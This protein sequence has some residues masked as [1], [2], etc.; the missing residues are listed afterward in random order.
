MAALTPQS[1]TMQTVPPRLLAAPLLTMRGR[2]YQVQFHLN[3]FNRTD[4]PV[5]LK[6]VELLWF[7]GGQQLGRRVLERPL[8]RRLLRAVPWP[9]M[10]DRKSIAA[11]HRWRGKLRRP[12]GHARV[13]AGAGVTLPHQLLITRE[14]RLPDGLKLVLVH[15]GGRTVLQVVVERF[16][17]RTRLRLP[18]RGR[19]WVMA[20]HRFDEHHG[21]GFINSQ[22]FS[23]DLGRLAAGHSTSSGDARQNASYKCH[24]QAVVA[25]ADGAVAEVHDNVPENTPVGARP[26]WQQVLRQPWDLAGNFV[27]LRHAPGEFTAYLHLR[28]GLA[29]KRGA[30]VKAGEVLGTCGNSGNSGEPHLHFQLQ[31]GPDPLRANGLPALLSD[32]T[33]HM[34]RLKVHVPPDQAAP[35]PSRLVLEPGRA[36]GAVDLA[37]VLR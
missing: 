16:T 1:L 4:R 24:G 18:V 17:Q 14:G 33:F 29:V 27:V 22:A 12:M 21:Q 31:D 9:V 7:K 25:A 34:G 32:F 8:L 13:P 10:S 23:Y 3:L 11:A 28:P 37:R 19:W 35:L 15:P 36:D 20:G 2:F 26:V 6:R 5:E 30:R